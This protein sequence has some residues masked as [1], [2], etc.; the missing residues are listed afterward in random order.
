MTNL[1]QFMKTDMLT[2]MAKNLIITNRDLVRN[3]PRLK[4]KLRCGETNQLIIPENG[5]RYIV[6][7]KSTIKKPGD[8]RE[9]LD[10]LEKMGPRKRVKRVHLG[11]TF[12][13]LK[14]FKKR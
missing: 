3:W 2:L 4:E 8:I 10:R 9:L 6:M 5:H 13:S 11:W 12:K 14:L 1:T 7:I